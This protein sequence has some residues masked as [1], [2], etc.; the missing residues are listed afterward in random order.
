ML[1]KVLERLGTIES[2]TL[3]LK[4][5]EG[6]K[7]RVASMLWQDA[8]MILRDG[9]LVVRNVDDRLHIA[10]NLRHH[11]EWH[12]PMALWAGHRRNDKVIEA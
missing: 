3:V 6:G 1:K 4:R 10:R 11:D 2:T 12:P 9:L 7:I 5:E 8:R